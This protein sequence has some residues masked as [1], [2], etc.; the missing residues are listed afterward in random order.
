MTTE[1]IAALGEKDR[2]LIYTVS[3]LVH[4]RIVLHILVPL[5]L[6]TG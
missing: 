1:T 2:V 5:Y 4:I 3:L 6:M